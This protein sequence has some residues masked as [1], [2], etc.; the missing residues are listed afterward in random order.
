MIAHREADL[1]E[2]ILA[3]RA[4]RGFAGRLDRGEQQRDQNANDGDDHEQL[5]QR[6]G[7]IGTHL[8]SGHNFSY[9][10]KQRVRSS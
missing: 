5:N 9:P 7:P 10:E 3:L 6:E 1:L 8:L 4:A 2:V